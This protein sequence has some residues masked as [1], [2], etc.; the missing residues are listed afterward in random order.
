MTR[1]HAH[2]AEADRLLVVNDHGTGF[3]DGEHHHHY[4]GVPDPRVT[5]QASIKATTAGAVLGRPIDQWDPADLGVHDSITVENETTLTPYLPRDHDTDL[6]GHLKDLMAAGAGSRLVLVVGTSCTGKTRALFEGVR[7]IL[8]GWQLV[9]P[10]TDS[11]LARIL[12]GGVPARTVVWLDELQDQLTK[13]SH[14]VTA[15]NAIHQLLESAE[16]GPILFT[17]TIWP[18][19]H[20]AL[21]ARPTPKESSDGAGAIS[22]LL[23]NAALVEV[24]ETF[25][26]ADLT[27]AQ[28]SKDAR[29]RK[30]YA[31]ASEISHPGHGHGHGRKITQVLAGGTQLANRL[32][33]PPDNAPP[34]KFSPAA[35]A[36]LHAAGDLRRIGMTNPIPRW[37]IEGAAPGYLQPPTTRPAH[38]WLPAALAETT[39]DATTDDATTGNRSLDI[40]TKGVPALTPNW[41]TTP[42]GQ[43]IEAYDL[44]DYLYQDHLNHHRASPT[45]PQLW[46]TLTNHHHH[47][48]D[49]PRLIAYAAERRGLLTIAI[50]LRRP[51]ADVGNEFVQF[52]FANLLATR[53]DETALTEL[54]TRADTG[55]RLALAVLI[56]LLATRGDETALTELR[57]RA[58]TGD[59]VA[60]YRLAE[61]LATRGDQADLTELQTRADTGDRSAQDRLAE[62][63]ATRGDEAALTEL[64][65]RADAGDEG[66][67]SRLTELLAE[68]GDQTALTE[69]RTHADAGERPARYQLA[70]LL[71]ARGDEDAL[72]ELRARAGS[73]DFFAGHVLVR[74]LA[75]RG[76]EAA[77]TELRTHADAGTRAARAALAELVANR[78]DDA[79]LTELRTPVL[80]VDWSARTTLPE[81]LANRGDQTALT[82]LRTRADTGDT[83]ARAVLADLLANRGDQTALTELRTR[84]DTGDPCAQDRLATLL[85]TRGDED[86]LTELRTR[87]NT[88][89]GPA[90]HQL[91][92]LLV[93]RGDEDALTELRTRANTGEGPARH[94]LAELLAALG[95]QT[96]LI[97][98]RTLV[99]TGSE[100][101]TLLEAYR[102]LSPDRYIAE[103]NCEARPVYTDPP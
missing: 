95:D 57:T 33:P 88:G 58:D 24:P 101:R 67:K 78:G 6:R 47:H 55:Q 73:G 12:L 48:L 62:L 22:K 8:P 92:T 85:V 31:T 44:H 74:L 84:A 89:E 102:R 81:L 4:P 37:A 42:D 94:Q 64:Q 79:A 65:T 14:G 63:L 3:Q 61:L 28:N 76:D 80:N 23:K 13:T 77:L 36:V 7:E 68:R 34:D 69:L 43:D 11:D 87:A 50:D 25:T 17:G 60:Q 9:A 21:N 1:D 100:G 10:G 49:D 53:G 5:V 39:R 29:L 40:H 83:A 90:Q 98:L 56:E 91:A 51:T 93:T 66:A 103:L 96:A 75:I 18:T 41:T 35:R 15:A 86:A 26:D 72:T 97:E 59:D 16:V 2:E 46:D 45:Q 71:A 32:H 82:E 20:D 19:N 99:L 30:A 38:T 54:R 70:E 27:T 52:E